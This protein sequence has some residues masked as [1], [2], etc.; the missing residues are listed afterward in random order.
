MLKLSRVKKVVK[1]NGIT[2]YQKHE[3]TLLR[4]KLLVRSLYMKFRQTRSRK[5]DVMQLNNA[6][7]YLVKHNI[8]PDHPGIAAIKDL[9]EEKRL[10]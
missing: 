6:G 1:I 10:E 2:Y 4:L 9:I 5:G 3:E 8:R 7:K